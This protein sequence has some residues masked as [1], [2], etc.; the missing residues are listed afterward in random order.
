[1]AEQALELIGDS[2]PLLQATTWLPLGHALRRTNNMAGAVR[3]YSEAA[4]ISKAVGLHLAVTNAFNSLA[5]SLTE[6]GHAGEAISILEDARHELVDGL[7]GP[8]AVTNLLS[9]SEAVTSYELNHVER[10]VELALMG[11][12]TGQQ[13][14]SNRILGGEIERVLIQ[15]YAAL[16]NPSAALEVIQEERMQGGHQVRWMATMIDA[17]EAE[18][19]RKYGDLDAAEYWAKTVEIPGDQPFMVT[20]ELIY[21]IYARLLL[22]T[23]QMREAQRV[24]NWLEIATR[25]GGRN[26]SLITVSILKS[27]TELMRNNKAAALGCLEEAVKLA[28]PCGYL[29]RFL[30]ER[31]ITDQLVKEFQTQL[32]KHK[33]LATQPF[34]GEIFRSCV[35]RD[36]SCSGGNEKTPQG[37]K[38]HCPTDL[39]LVEPLSEQE[40]RVLRLLS[41]GKTNQEIAATLRATAEI[42]TDFEVLEEE[43]QPVVD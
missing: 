21:I 18:L 36:A 10:A 2:D 12:K 4:S 42:T 20:H 24:L 31:E 6:M 17:L 29:R 23:K 34:L 39:G 30:N 22:E 7:G 25:Q 16:D 33:S 9:I 38:S 1:M 8:L 11:K 13:I 37:I 19:N 15:A 35:A 41:T 43:L 32:M 3:A 27:Y 5:I 28:A 26:A 14:L 40:I